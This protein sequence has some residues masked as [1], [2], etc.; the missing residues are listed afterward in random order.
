MIGFR[1]LVAVIAAVV[2]SI[3]SPNV[4][5]AQSLRHQTT[6]AHVYV[7]RSFLVFSSGLFDLAANF[8]AQGLNATVHNQLEWPF[9]ADQAIINYREGL[10]A[11]IIIIGHSSGTNAALSMTDRFGSSRRRAKPGNHARPDRR[12]SHR[13][14]ASCRQCLHYQSRCSGGARANRGR[15]ARHLGTQAPQRLAC[16][17]GQ[18]VADG[19]PIDSD[20]RLGSRNA[21]PGSKIPASPGI[22]AS[23]QAGCCADSRRPFC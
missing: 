6:T 18:I 17:H 10:E 20:F 2:C 9:L 7:L 5:S 1:H 23:S 15:S 8:R 13:W 16:L 12:R 14:Q 3:L 21:R 11:P 22:R 4:G 19:G